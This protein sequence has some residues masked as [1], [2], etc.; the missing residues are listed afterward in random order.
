MGIRENFKRGSIEMLILYLLTQEDMYGY[1]LAQEINS[2]SDGQ[3]D[4]TEG[5]MYP[6]LY[7]LIEKKAISDYKK[8]S[9]KRRTRVYY[10]IEKEGVELLEKIKEDYHAI[11]AGVEKILSGKGAPAA[12]AA[13]STAAKAPARGRKKKTQ[14]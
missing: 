9:G 14:E 12:P 8:L 3:F 4:I 7:R 1:Q 5:S 13:K 10:H 2:R 6:T 11:N